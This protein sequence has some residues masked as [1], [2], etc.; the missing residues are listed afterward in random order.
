M[1]AHYTSTEAERLSIMLEKA[2]LDLDAIV[3]QAVS[4]VVQNHLME[5]GFSD[6]S[7]MILPVVSFDSQYAA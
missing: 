3:E 1:A 6:G 2:E 7:E 5:I 4:V